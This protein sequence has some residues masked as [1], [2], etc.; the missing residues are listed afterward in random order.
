MPTSVGRLSLSMSVGVH[1]GDVALFLVGE[2]TRELLVLGP[3][4]TE[5]ARAEKAASAGQVVVSPATARRLR[6]GATRPREDG[7]LVLRRRGPHSPQGTAQPVPGADDALLRTLFPVALGEYLAPGPPDPEHR[8]ATI[9]FVRFSGTDAI[10]AEQGP[11]PLAEAL[12]AVVTTVEAALAAEGVTLLATDLDTDGGKFFL[13]SGVPATHEDDEGRMLRALR[14]IADADLPLP[15]QLGVNRG[16]VFAAEVG[17]DRAGGLLGH[18]RHHQHGGPDHGHGAGRRHPRAPRRARALPHPLRRDT[19]RALRDEGQGRSRSSVYAVGEEI[20][21]REGVDDSRLPFLG[22]EEETATVRRALEE[23]LSGAG[24]VITVDGRHRDGQVAP[25]AR[26]PRAGR[27]GRD[28][29]APA[30][31]PR[32]AVRCVEHLP[33]AA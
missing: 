26:G 29:R 16:H 10:L 13:G 15:L 11:G 14:R 1:S 27:G 6:P 3:A 12:H 5:T 19:R 31:R 18:G 17:V 28:G 9:A 30:G 23:A 22:R 21:T 24:G 33:D 25:G 20:G 32:R 7:Q 8:V 2:P 4:A